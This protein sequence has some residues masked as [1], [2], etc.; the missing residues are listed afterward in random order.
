[1][2][3]S[4]GKVEDYLKGPDRMVGGEPPLTSIEL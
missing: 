3:A 1:M 2:P 4:W